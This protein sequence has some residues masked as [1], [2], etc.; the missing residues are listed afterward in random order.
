MNATNPARQRALAVAA[1]ST[2]LA[3]A[4]G[5]RWMVRDYA[6][7]YAPLGMMLPNP[8]RLA[9]DHLGWVFAWPV[10]LAG[11]AIHWKQRVDRGWPLLVI[12][13]GGGALLF[14]LALWAMYLPTMPLG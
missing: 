2:A 6:A 3:I 10:V 9:I 12:A 7:T 1:I 8:T 4:F 13:L 11:L 14:G 5:I